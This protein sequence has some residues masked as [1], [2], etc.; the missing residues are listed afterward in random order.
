MNPR[1]HCRLAQLQVQLERL[2]QCPAM[3]ERVV[4]P[5]R[6]HRGEVLV[7]GKR[8]NGRVQLLQFGGRRTDDPGTPRPEHPLVRAGD[9]VVAV[10][11]GK[12]HVFDAEAMHT[13]DH[14]NDLVLL[15]T[16]AIDLAHQRADLAH[17]Q[18]HATARVHPG[19]AQHPGFRPDG[20]RD[21]GQYL[22]AVDLGGVFEQ[23]QPVHRCAIARGAKA[24]G[25]AGGRMLVHGGE[26]FLPRGNLQPAI[27]Q[28]QAFG[29]AAGQGDLPGR[30]FEVAG[31][32]F[33]HGGF[34][35]PLR[36][37]VPVDHAGRVAV[38]AGTQ[39][40]DGFAHGPWVRGDQEVG[41]VRIGRVQL[42]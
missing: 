10:E 28:P 27:D 6:H 9:E 21:G 25:M 14:I 19:H 5:G 18:F 13:V 31:R 42:E 11:I 34:V 3:L 4:A 1:L 40:L 26:N 37:A 39:R 32:P 7:L 29:G 30:H 35:L 16:L 8:G 12:A 17:G 22:V 33:T 2:A 36:L 15:V 23:A 20:R 24:H 41:K 38:E